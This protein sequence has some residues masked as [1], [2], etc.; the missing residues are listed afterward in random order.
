MGIFIWF[1]GLVVYQSK[2]KPTISLWDKVTMRMT[3]WEHEDDDEGNGLVSTVRS[4][5]YF[6]TAH[7]LKIVSLS[8]I[9]PFRQLHSV[10]SVVVWQYKKSGWLTKRHCACCASRLFYPADRGL[11][12]KRIEPSSYWLNHGCVS[13]VSWSFA[14]ASV[15]LKVLTKT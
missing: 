10:L 7:W 1:M 6:F 8:S 14:P 5:W 9:S 4:C 3:S 2:P 13:I 15:L 11:T 12:F